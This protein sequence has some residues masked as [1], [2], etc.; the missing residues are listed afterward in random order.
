MSLPKSR[1]GPKDR[2]VL[3][4]EAIVQTTTD[5]GERKWGIMEMLLLLLLLQLSSELSDEFLSAS[6]SVTLA[7]FNLQHYPHLGLFSSSW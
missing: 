7:S 3:G 4:A 5:D 2:S 6:L 1:Y